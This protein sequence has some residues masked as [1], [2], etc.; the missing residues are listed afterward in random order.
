V[1]V[2]P[3]GLEVSVPGAPTLWWS[4]DEVRQ[5]QG[6]Y[7]GEQVRLERVGAHTDV[8]VVEDAALVTALARAWGRPS[9]R[10]HDP[11][12]RGR[13]L[14]LTVLAAL[15]AVGF[16]GGLYLWGIP[17]LAEVTAARVPLG[18]EERLGQTVAE[19]LAPARRRCAEPERLQRLESILLEVTRRLP[20]HPYTFR[21]VVVDDD[22][23][24]AFAAPGG[25]L[26]VLR[27]LLEFVAT[28]DELAGVFAHEVQHVVRRHTTQALLRHAS[29]GLLLAAAAGDLSGLTAFGLESARTLGSLRYGRRAEEE[30]DREGMRLLIAGG[31]DPASMIAF[32]EALARRDSGPS[33]ASWTRYLSSHPATEARLAELRALAATATS[34]PRRLLPDY[35]WSDMARICG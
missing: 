27:G 20:A 13:R 11:A 15:G 10:L 9:T 5:T 14:R 1:R 21:L 35:D 16:G 32:F 17:A 33:R 7:A 30:A 22:D 26:I 2:F 34:P 3:S 28:P 4:R 6:F 25:H 23:V 31:L 29:T 8:V 19:H 24:N 18:W 12:R